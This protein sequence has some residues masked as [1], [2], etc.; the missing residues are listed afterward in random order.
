[1]LQYTAGAI[2][3]P[4]DCWLVQ[5]GIKTLAVRMERHCQN[6]LALA[7]WLADHPAVEQVLY[8][9]LP[10]H[11]QHELA[12]RQ[13]RH[14]G[15]MLSFTL[16]GGAAAALKLVTRTKLFTLAV[17]LGGVESLIE[18]PAGMT[19]ATTANSEL[20][21]NPALVRLSVGIEHIDD[22]RDDLA[23]ALTGL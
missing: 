3:G 12:K 16:T 8:P 18:V 4:Q 20:A 11:P 10:D 7:Q 9:G 23:A 19:H 14:F 6:A 21:V 22:L 5:R 15:G 13:M 2:P 1:M 17:S